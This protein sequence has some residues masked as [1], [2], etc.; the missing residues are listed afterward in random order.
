MKRYVSQWGL[1]IGAIALLIVVVISTQQKVSAQA[2]RPIPTKTEVNARADVSVVTVSTASYASTV[3]AFGAAEPHFSLNLTAQVAGQV[4]QLSGQ[5]EVGNHIKA[6]DWLIKLENSNYEA[7]LATTNYNLSEAKLA[8]LEEQRLGQ[9][10]LLEW[11]ASGLSG[12]PDSDLVLRQ[13]QLEAATAA[14]TNAEK[15][16]QAAK[17]DLKQS[18]IT[19]PFD[20]IITERFVAPGSYIQTGT[21][22]ASLN[23]TDRIEVA[24]SLSSQDWQQLPSENM[25]TSGKWPVILSRVEDGQQW[26]AYVLRSQQHLQGETRQRD[27]IVALDAPFE[28]SPALF[29][30]TFIK[31]SIDGRMVDGLWKLPNTALSQRGE[32]WYLN[33]DNSLNKLQTTPLFARDEFIYIATPEHLATSPQRVLIHPLNSY[34]KGMQVNPIENAT[35]A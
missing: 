3:E 13:P 14:V 10:A 28:Q 19:S 16:L 31:A 18:I 4:E 26:T 23:S 15:A 5:F 33:P 21:E 29:P 22:I 1:L 24:I 2:D 17:K 11:K 20:A 35:D 27:L 30:G 12:E 25:L 6:S 8:L 34:L 32:I 9:Q 7:M